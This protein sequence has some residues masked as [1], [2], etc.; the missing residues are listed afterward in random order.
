[1]AP[2]E[3]MPK[4]FNVEE[5]NQLLPQLRLILRQ[6]KEHRERIAKF[7]SA[8]ALEQLS[9]L[10][11]DGTV[12]SQAQ[13]EVQRID[14]AIGEAV[15]TLEEE[16]E[17]LAKLGAQLKDLDEGLVDFFTAR[18]TKLVYL[19]WKEGE[20]RIRYWHDLESGFAGRRPVEEL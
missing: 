1:M 9:W 18:G 2:S 7:E 8:K 3:E 12:S 17:A 5:A 19:C 13:Q 14:K 16:L 20:D 4:L 10:R 11:E 6:V 15:H